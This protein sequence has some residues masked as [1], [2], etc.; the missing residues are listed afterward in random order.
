MYSSFHTPGPAAAA[1]ANPV[2]FS[3]SSS[4][5]WSIALSSYLI[6]NH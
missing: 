5:V 3:S 1:A 4:S 6:V 2:S